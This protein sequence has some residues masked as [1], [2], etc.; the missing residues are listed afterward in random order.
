MF[1]IF[2]V[3]KYFLRH[4]CSEIFLLTAVIFVAWLYRQEIVLL[5]KTS[6]PDEFNK[7][8]LGVVAVFGAILSPFV[9]WRIARRQAADNIS[10][11]R[12]IWIDEFRKEAADLSSLTT[13]ILAEDRSK[14]KES[15]NPASRSASPSEIEAMKTSFLIRLR[16]SETIDH[17]SELETA[18][19][20]LFD[21][22]NKRTEEGEMDPRFEEAFKEKLKEFILI[23]RL[24]INDE[25]EKIRKGEI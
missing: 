5:A 2:R 1:Y 25:W 18:M 9:Q 16:I 11:K 21:A 19:C 15:S 23:S 7:V 10:A 4:I 3:R 13:L 14:Q 22:A 20:N 24:I 17:G 12:K 6:S 8:A